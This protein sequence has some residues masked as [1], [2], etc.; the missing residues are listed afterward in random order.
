MRKTRKPLQCKTLCL[1]LLC[2]GGFASL[3]WFGVKAALHHRHAADAELLKWV[4]EQTGLPFPTDATVVKWD[5]DG[6]D[7]L[8]RIWLAKV[9]FGLSGRD[10]FLQALSAKPCSQAILVNSRHES[11]LWWQPESVDMHRLYDMGESMV[12]VELCCETGNTVEV[13]IKHAVY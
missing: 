6:E 4:A 10:A 2:I 8:D 5:D 7:S 12:Y 13:Y 3:S 11:T 9:V 1:V